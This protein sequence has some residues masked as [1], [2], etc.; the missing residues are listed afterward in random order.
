MAAEATA[1][2]AVSAGPTAAAAEAPGFTA[3]AGPTAAAA[4]A[5][6]FTAA[7]QATTA[8]A[9]APG[10]TAAAAEPATFTAESAAFS[11]AA[12]PSTLV[13]GAGF[14]EAASL[15][16]RCARGIGPCG[17]EARAARGRLET[18]GTGASFVARAV[19][20]IAAAAARA[21]YADHE[22]ANAKQAKLRIDERHIFLRAWAG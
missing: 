17:G 7:A 10:F 5:P 21:K 22:E 1:T 4:E 12:E 9:E 2:A 16:R 15:R 14:I 8:A 18:T 3:A 11:A 20:R 6:G 19:I 13:E